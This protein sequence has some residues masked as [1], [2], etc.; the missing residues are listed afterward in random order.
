MSA[1]KQSK[2]Q[3][4]SKGKVTQIMKVGT[5]ALVIGYKEKKAVLLDYFSDDREIAVFESALY[6]GENKPLQYV[7]LVRNQT[8]KEDEEF[9][10][11]IE[12]LLSR[13]F[14]RPDI[15]EHGVKW[16]KSKIR[17]EQYKKAESEAAQ[18][19]AEYAFKLFQ[20][21]PG[22]K[23]Y[24]LAGAAAQVKIRVFT[25]SEELSFSQAA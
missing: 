20:E 22:R 25:L 5:V 19:I 9:A 23:E 15:Q 4:Y 17:V 12:E 10:N 6:S 21:N 16:L 18:V 1:E 8:Q 24:F 2:A 13:P 3:G 11:Y 14:I 7:Y